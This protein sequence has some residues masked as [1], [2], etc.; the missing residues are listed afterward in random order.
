VYN[1]ALNREKA[2]G[3][4]T[5]K[6][7]YIPATHEAQSIAHGSSTAKNKALIKEMKGW[8]GACVNV[9]SDEIGNLDLRLYEK[10]GENIEEVTEH[11]VL[12]LLYRVNEW[13]TKFDHFWLTQAYLELAGEAP[14]FIERE[15]GVPTNIYFLSPDKIT[16][17]VGKDR[18]VDGYKYRIS[19]IKEVILD[20]EDVIF[21][22]YP[23]PAN[24]F[25][26][27]GTLEQA[28]SIVDLDNFSELWNRK[29][30]ENSARPDSVLTVKVD[31]MTQQQKEELKTSIRKAYQGID[32]SHG[33]MV[34]FGDMELDTFGFSQK[35]MDFTEQQKFG[36]DKILGI[37][38]VP[39]AII[40][41]TEGTNF[42]SSRV[43]TQ[44]FSRYT[45]TPKMER[46]VQ[47]LNE[48]LLPLF[49]G[50]E[51]LFLDY[52]NPVPE[53]EESKAK[54]YKDALEA[55]Y[56]TINEVRTLEGMPEI[57]G[58]DTL[59]LSNTLVPIEQVG[60]TG[61]PLVEAQMK[62]AK[63]KDGE[64]KK[65]THNKF[66]HRLRE[67]R[68]RNKE[69]IDN[70]K[71]K[72]EVN[73]V[74]KEVIR[75]SYRDIALKKKEKKT[76]RQVFTEDEKLV[77]W[78]V[79]NDIYKSYLEEVETAFGEIFVKQAKIVLT[80]FQ[81]YTKGVKLDVNQIYEDIKLN[82]KQEIARTVAVTLPIFT[83]LY[84]DSGNET[85]SLLES[86]MVMDMD[87]DEVKKLL[88]TKTRQMAKSATVTTN[89]AIKRTLI[90][91]LSKG[92]N[93]NELAKRL[94]G[95]FKEAVDSR[96]VMI[97]RTETARYN[98]R[99]SEQAFIDSG[100]VEG[101]EWQCDPDPCAQCAT[102]CGA[103]IG[104]GK[105]YLEQGGKINEVTFDYEDILGPP[106]HPNCQCDL[107]PIFKPIKTIKTK[108]ESVQKEEKSK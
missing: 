12:D 100:L 8:V 58:G 63:V 4:N 60:K 40:A 13:T 38:R 69:E 34:L 50:T 5:D 22:K 15:N 85:F 30:Y 36:R 106:L 48:F 108:Q 74:V 83:A 65:I 59:Y 54:V 31:Q 37:F 94:K 39:K 25:R 82:E 105:T 24:Q 20:V 1:A 52:E 27:L 32:K 76:P 88:N 2:T 92:E 55:G 26:G 93:V 89:E 10:N 16:P 95:V 87:R 35:D 70:E 45:I 103:T 67:N 66:R 80:S 91:G 14:W 64:Q 71:I 18:L 46:L 90:D 81:K 79:K 49:K 9:I 99:A 75:K 17:I 44:V 42:A 3:S 104:L 23:N 68:A 86:E 43:A 28:A 62:R 73:E 53:D 29:F 61:E 47:Q 102:L 84:E 21:L 107:I 11:P 7:P 97:A 56:M 57:E 6:K 72:K 78:K 98:V 33:T 51:K 19:S 41:Q 96:A 77:F 101:K